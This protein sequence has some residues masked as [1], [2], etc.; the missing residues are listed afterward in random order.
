MGLEA[1]HIHSHGNPGARD[2]E[3]TDIC[4][5][6]INIKRFQSSSCALS[7]ACYVH[8]LCITSHNLNY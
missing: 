4:I 8:S 1:S 3:I 6:Q 2:F 5:K 7:S